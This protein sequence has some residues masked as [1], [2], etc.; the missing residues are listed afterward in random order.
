MEKVRYSKISHKKVGA[1]LILKYFGK[2]LT[3]ENFP[4]LSLKRDYEDSNAYMEDRLVVVRTKSGHYLISYRSKPHFKWDG[5]DRFYCDTFVQDAEFDTKFDE[6]VE[7]AVKIARKDPKRIEEERKRRLELYLKYA[8]FVAEELGIPRLKEKED[9]LEF[10]ENYFEDDK[11]MI[12]ANQTVEFDTVA[13]LKMSDGMH[14]VLTDS[15][16]LEG[17][18][19]RYLSDLYHKA[20]MSRE[21]ACKGFVA[22]DELFSGK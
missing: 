14:L 4:R 17:K 2:P 6:L 13:Y 3:K 19:T 16:M 8:R 18:W 12:L 21:N 10:Y 20:R 11:L 7:K 22:D 5:Q 9:Y 1:D 15:M